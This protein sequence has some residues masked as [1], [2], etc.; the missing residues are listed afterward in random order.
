[1]STHHDPF[2]QQDFFYICVSHLNDKGFAAPVVD[3]EAEA[4]KKKKELR[5][6][7]IQKVKDEYEEKQRKKKSKKS[8]KEDEKDKDKKKDD[9]DES[10]A[11][12]ERDDKVSSGLKPESKATSTHAKLPQ[13]KAIEAGTGGNGKTEDVPRIYTLHR[14]V[15]ISPRCS[16]KRNHLLS[17]SPR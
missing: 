3:A 13:I 8:S 4:A 17:S 16:W 6:Q 7:E 10:K 2:Q 1:M 15:L 12:K 9:D 14:L 11:E 5:D